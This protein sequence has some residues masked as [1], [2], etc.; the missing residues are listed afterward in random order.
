M[1]LVRLTNLWV[2][3]AIL[4]TLQECEAQEFDTRHVPEFRVLL[5]KPDAE[6]IGGTMTKVSVRFAMQA[7]VLEPIEYLADLTMNGKEYAPFVITTGLDTSGT[8]IA[9]WYVCVPFPTAELRMKLSGR[10]SVSGKRYEFGQESMTLQIKKVIV[11]R[12]RFVVMRTYCRFT[13]HC[14]RQS[15]CT[16]L[17][18]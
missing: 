17:V 15:T 14:C 5:P 1:S 4:G 7:S 16:K 12:S 11:Q 9:S 2:C 13:S 18:R 8:A 3:L 6:L 10:G